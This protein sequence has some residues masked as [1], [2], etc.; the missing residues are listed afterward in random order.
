MIQDEDSGLIQIA[1]QAPLSE[2]AELLMRSYELGVE[3]IAYEYDTWL[4]V[5]TK[6]V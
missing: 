6:E 1:F 4:K 5:I 3:E 2:K